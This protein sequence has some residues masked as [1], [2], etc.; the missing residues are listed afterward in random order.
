[1]VDGKAVLD[2]RAH[3]IARDVGGKKVSLVAVS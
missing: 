2:P 3:G 1:V